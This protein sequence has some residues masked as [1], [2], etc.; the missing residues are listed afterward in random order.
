MGLN[1]EISSAVFFRETL[2]FFFFLK[3]FWTKRSKVNLLSE[4][5]LY[6]IISFCTFVPF[7]ARFLTKLLKTSRNSLYEHSKSIEN[8]WKLSNYGLSA[9][10]THNCLQILYTMQSM[11]GSSTENLYFQGNFKWICFKNYWRVNHFWK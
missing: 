9:A 8:S 1:Q 2:S 6:Y 5:K 10:E 4:N 11:P 7:L 3:L